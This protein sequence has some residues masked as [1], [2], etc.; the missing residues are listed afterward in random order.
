MFL[1]GTNAVYSRYSYLYIQ[2]SERGLIKVVHPE[3]FSANPVTLGQDFYDVEQGPF[4]DMKRPRETFENAHH[5]QERGE[6]LGEGKLHRLV[7]QR[8]D[9]VWAEEGGIGGGFAFAKR[10]ETVHRV[11]DVRCLER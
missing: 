8:D 3:N 6:R 10:E 5:L 9:G 1:R 11:N 4:F 7:V 2:T